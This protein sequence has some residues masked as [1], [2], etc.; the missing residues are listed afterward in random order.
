MVILPTLYLTGAGREGGD[1]R[2]VQD[3]QLVHV[4]VEYDGG[5]VHVSAPG[6]RVHLGE[7]VV[8]EL[9]D[10]RSF[11]HA[12]STD[13]CDTQRL[14]HSGSPGSAP[15][16]AAAVAAAAAAAETRRRTQM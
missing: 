8:D 3:L 6:R 11:P 5:P 9:P 12:G 1:W 14:H 7:V 16:T 2:D 4:A 10:H 13:D 15:W